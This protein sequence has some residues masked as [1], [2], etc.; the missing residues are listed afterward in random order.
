MKIL[1][2]TSRV[3]YPLEKGDK[4]RIFNQIK[5][6][7]KEHEVIVCAIDTE[8]SSLSSIEEVKKHCHQLHVLTIP[9]WKVI[10]QLFLGLFSSLPFQVSYFYNKHAQKKI[11]E[12]IESNKPD[13][14]YSHLIRTSEY[15]KNAS[16]PKILDYMDAFSIGIQRRINKQYFF[17]RWIYKMEYL[18]LK[19]YE[20]DIYEYFDEH[21]IITASD[22]EHIQHP[23][24][25]DI[26]IIPNGIDTDFFKR[27]R[28]EKKYDILFTGNMNYPPNVEAA[29]YLAK[30][31]VPLL[32]NEFQEVKLLIAG[33][34]PHP[35]VKSLANENV[36]ISGWVDD[37]RT[38]YNESKVFVAPMQIG[39]GLQNKLLEAMSMQL[40]C[41][42]SELANASLNAEVNTE[43]LIGKTPED[44][45]NHIKNLLKDELKSSTLANKGYEFVINRYGWDYSI[46]ILSELIKKTVSKRS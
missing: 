40:P 32:K 2:V 28:V 44:Y 23:L 4:L 15:V 20:S 1:I 13:L 37:I 17:L 12:I 6:L 41:I 42:T 16:A 31:V 39:T 7:N 26:Q 3:P 11:D 8:G 29:V 43:V 27:T 5:H 34:N 10:L 46:S 24:R 14:I 35:Q 33:A 18:R 38:C 30:K 9:K 21:S 45:A 19:K 22:R 36:I 25:N